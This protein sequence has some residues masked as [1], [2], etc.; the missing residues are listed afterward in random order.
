MTLLKTLNLSKKFGCNYALEKVSLTIEPGKV[1]GLVGE[2]G[3]GKSTF[4]KLI[5]GV[6]QADEGKIFWESKETKISNYQEASKL[7]IGVIHQE[8][9]LIPFFTG[10]ENI[11]LGF[12]YH[13]YKRFPMIN[14]KKMR[15]KVEQLRE[16][17]GVDVP[18]YIPVKDLTPTQCTIIEILRVMMNECKLLILDEPT[19]TLTEQESQPLFRLIEKLLFKGSSIIYVSHR[20]NE[21]TKLCN[22]VFVFCNGKMKLALES[23][24]VTEEKLV[25][26]M[27]NRDI[28]A[29]KVTEKNKI[30]P[31]KSFLEVRNIST[32]DNKVKNASL[33][34]Y[35]GEVLGIFGLTGSGRTELLESIYGLRDIYKGEI[36]LDNE[37]IEKLSPRKSLKKGIALI[38]EDR[39][40]YGMVNKMSVQENMTLSVL[41]NFSKGGVINKKSEKLHVLKWINKMNIKINN[42]KQKIEELSGGNQQKVVL[43][44]ALMSNPRVLLC[45]EPTQG[46]DVITRKE[47]NRL[48][49][50]QVQQGKSVIYVSSDLKEMMEVSDRLLIMQ[51]GEIIETVSSEHLNE[52]Y[53]LTL[54][55]SSQEKGEFTNC[56][57]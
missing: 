52:E 56:R 22:Q 19:A 16:E 17:L 37:S 25:A 50:Q 47:I 53:I 15:Y 49:K 54:C 11:F 42:V 41:Y 20:L 13:T 9:N 34:A 31:K 48:L 45:D 10:M 3:A 29:F 28:N 7:G 12:K 1:Y 33:F 44:K 18:L 2:N 24:D 32:K 5:T 4:I 39:L 21:I 57:Q 14:W 27:T 30:R 46:V 8:R 35:S 6:Y 40:T 55:H 36:I 51:N 26:V 43:A 38:T 23:K